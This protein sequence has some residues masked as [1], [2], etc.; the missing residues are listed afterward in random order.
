LVKREQSVLFD[1]DGSI[2]LGQLILDRIFPLG[3]KLCIDEAGH[4]FIERAWYQHAQ[5]SQMEACDA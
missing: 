1:V 5:L 3:I 2:E 4:L